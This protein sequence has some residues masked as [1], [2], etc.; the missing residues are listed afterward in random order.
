MTD[1]QATSLDST[2]G[3]SSVLD[4]VLALASLQFSSMPP[5]VHDDSE[6]GAIS[7]GLAMLSEELEASVSSLRS[8]KQEA[9]EAAQA[10]EV[11]LRNVSHE[12]RTPLTAVMGMTE[13][14]LDT[15]LTAEQREYLVVSKNALD[16]LLDLVTDLLDFSKLEAGKTELEEVAF[17]IE[18]VVQSTV[19]IMSESARDKGLGVAYTIEPGVPET[20]AGDP[21]R[22]R[23]VLLNLLGNAV[24]FS[25]AGNISV[26]VSRL[27]HPGNDIMLRFSVADN[28]IGVPEDLQEQIFEA[29]AQADG[30]TTREF[31]GTGLGLA[32]ASQIV[33][34]LG[35]TMSVISEVDLGS[36]F[37]FTCRFR[38]V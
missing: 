3:L 26:H 34:A 30:S 27:D 11:F 35:G 20:M 21:G 32:I 7:A 28:G 5:I 6:L 24:K 8:A 12:L 2:A 18:E 16:S 13:L 10:K 38:P 19:Q 1:I 31:G 22:L 14:C 17:Q 9:I 29:F 4:Q 25:E 33:D 36:D 23:Q 37:T 15:E